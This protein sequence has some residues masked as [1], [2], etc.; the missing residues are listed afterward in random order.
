ML[1]S[2]VISCDLLF[3]LSLGFRYYNGDIF[4]IEDEDGRRSTGRR[5]LFEG[6]LAERSSLWDNMDFWENIFLD[7]VATEREAVGMNQG[8]AE[9]IDRYER[10]NLGQVVILAVRVSR[11]TFRV[12]RFTFRVSRKSDG[13]SLNFKGINI[14]T[15]IFFFPVHLG[16][17]R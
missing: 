15:A 7:A 1:S 11:F 16:T 4:P 6:L 10:E 2:I 9:M 12:S 14:E 17:T 13:N 3:F 8:P 5:Y